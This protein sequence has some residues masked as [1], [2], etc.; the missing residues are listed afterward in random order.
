MKR[1]RRSA[2]LAG[3][4]I[5]LFACLSDVALA[6]DVAD[7]ASDALM[8]PML[9]QATEQISGM[10]GTF[11]AAILSLAGILLGY[12]ILAGV[13]QTAH[14]GEMLGRRWSSMWMPIRLAIGV[15][16]IVPTPSGFCT[17]QIVVNY[18]AK[19]GVTAGAGIWGGYVRMEQEKAIKDYKL[20][21]I[22]GIRDLAATMFVSQICSVAKQKEVQEMDPESRTAS[23]FSDGY[24]IQVTKISDTEYAIG[25][26][27]DPSACGGYSLPDYGNDETG[28]G[29]AHKEAT[30]I[31]LMRMR[32]LAA[33]VSDT[34]KPIDQAAT[35][36]AISSAV[37]EYQSR[38]ETAAA[39]NIQTQNTKNFNTA[40]AANS[41]SWMN[42][43]AYFASQGTAVSSSIGVANAVPKGMAPKETDKGG[44]QARGE[45][46][47]TTP[48][49]QDK[50]FFAGLWDSAKG[51]V[52]S[53]ASAVSDSVANAVAKFFNPIIAPFQNI[54]NGTGNP[55]QNMQSLGFVCIGAGFA[56]L[57]GSAL[58]YIVS[59]GAAMVLMGIAASIIGFGMMNA[60]YLPIVP[61]MTYYGGVI[62]WFV[63]YL[64]CLIAA[65]I[66]ALM[67]LLAGGEGMVGSAQS[68]YKKIVI[69]FLRPSLLTLSFSL[70]MGSMEMLIK[71]WNTAFSAAFSANLTM[72]GWT[73]LINLIPMFF[74]YT[75]TMIP[76]MHRIMKL[77]NIIP[78]A[79]TNWI[80]G[81]DGHFGSSSAEHMSGQSHGM[82]MAGAAFAGNAGGQMLNSAMNSRNE[83]LKQQDAKEAR[84]AA[85][86]DRAQQTQVMGRLADAIGA[87][88]INPN[89]PPY[90]TPN[91]G[92]GSDGV[93]PKCGKSPCECGNNSGG[94]DDSN[95]NNNG[96][97][98]MNSVPRGD[99]GGTG[100]MGGESGGVD[101][102]GPSITPSGGEGAG[103]MA[104]GAE[105]GAMAGG[106]EA[107]AAGAA[108]GPVGIAA[109]AAVTAASMAAEVGGKA[110]EGMTGAMSNAASSMSQEASSDSQ[111]SGGGS[112][113]SE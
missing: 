81:S 30:D 110:A 111:S 31:L 41:S 24:K 70:V 83:K 63:I 48:N 88:G 62:G 73:G 35:Q 104:G 105:G 65:P 108:L 20:P 82:A 87:L 100:G 94:G 15:A 51:A 113:Q 8:A 101:A 1:L 42:A 27:F 23:G 39:A 95:N 45:Q 49:G 96:G 22:S 3:L 102:G 50:G 33:V 68:G 16:A 69:L 91:G 59:G 25:D 18:I 64:E 46:S 75:I 47:L 14:D 79:I 40:K 43:G 7:A 90:L 32:D 11:N 34:S 85:A 76:I 10:F 4:A 92:G 89:D 12:N 54:M 38:I 52:S 19:A 93:C 55:I 97:G 66:W 67:H 106:M 36:T 99:S 21:D 71:G 74:V 6:A 77:I 84:N 57:A 103:A 9:D 13:A 2:W 109:G 44:L 56:A 60:Y 112:Q 80:D 28:I 26:G 37:A 86:S 17:A 53:A 58:L 72:T 107:T 5:A 98:G 78:E 61:A 29:Q